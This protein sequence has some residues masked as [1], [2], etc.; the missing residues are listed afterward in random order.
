MHSCLRVM[1]D[2]R[3][4]ARSA[5]IRPASAATYRSVKERALQIVTGSVGS[6]S[7]KEDRRRTRAGVSATQIPYA[8][9]GREREP[10]AADQPHD[11]ASLRAELPCGG[12]RSPACVARRIARQHAIEGDAR[13]QERHTCENAE[14]RALKRRSASDTAMISL[15]ARTFVNGNVGSTCQ[16]A[17]FSCATKFC[18]QSR[19]RSHIQIHSSAST[20][21][22]CAYGR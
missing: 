22:D 13:E 18:D 12:C 3:A 15:M 17:R 7:R 8:T 10:A 1:I 2:P 4:V 6:Q 20:N 19:W 11:I 5:E 9:R 16:T 21:R 14:Q